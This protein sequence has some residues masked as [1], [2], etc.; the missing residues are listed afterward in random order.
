MS[1]HAGGTLSPAAI[2]TTASSK[3]QP[4]SQ[5]LVI[6]S[7]YVINHLHNIPCSGNFSQI[8]SLHIEM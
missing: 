5:Y 3:F 2:S 7:K 1:N 8:L 6:P 4:P